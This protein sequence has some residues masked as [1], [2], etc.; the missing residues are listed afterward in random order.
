M[1]PFSLCP[2][3]R[4]V[5]NRSPELQR[6]RGKKEEDA[7]VA[8]GLASTRHSPQKLPHL[9]AVVLHHRRVLPSPL[10]SAPSSSPSPE[11]RRRPIV[12]VAD[13]LDLSR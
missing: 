13:A 1:R 3:L 4:C 6:S 9:A 10:V 7:A 12:V 5:G 8:R 11:P 2:V